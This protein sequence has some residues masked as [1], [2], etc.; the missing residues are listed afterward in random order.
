[1]ASEKLVEKGLRKEGRVRS[2][3]FGKMVINLTLNQIVAVQQWGKSRSEPIEMRGE[4]EEELSRV[5][6]SLKYIGKRCTGEGSLGREEL[7]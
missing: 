4:K 5:A 2:R 1:M 7:F 3:D 6:S